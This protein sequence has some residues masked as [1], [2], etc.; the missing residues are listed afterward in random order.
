MGLHRHVG[1]QV[2]ESTVGLLTPVPAALVHTL[3]FL[4]PATRSLV[5]LR[6]GD[7]NERVDLDEGM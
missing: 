4:V 2:V 3:N 7:W 1:V 5:L 6:T